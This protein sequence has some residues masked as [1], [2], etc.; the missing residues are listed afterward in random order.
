MTKDE[1][2]T[3]IMNYL[4][5]VPPKPQDALKTYTSMKTCFP[6]AEIPEDLQV[7]MQ[8]S[9]KTELVKLRDQATKQAWQEILR[10][11]DQGK[12]LYRLSDWNPD[13]LVL[14]A[15][16]LSYEGRITNNEGKELVQAILKRSGLS[17]RTRAE[18]WYLQDASNLEMTPTN[19]GFKIVPVTTGATKI[20]IDFKDSTDP[21]VQLFVGMAWRSLS[22]RAEAIKALESAR[23]ATSAYTKHLATFW[24]AFEHWQQGRE[25]ETAGATEAAA[26]EYAAAAQLYEEVS[27]T[28]KGTLYYDQAVADYGSIGQ[29]Y[30]AVKDCALNTQLTSTCSCSTEERGRVLLPSGS[31]VYCCSKKPS[32]KPCECVTD[33]SSAACACKTSRSCEDY[34]IQALCENDPCK[35]SGGQG[36]AS[37]ECAWRGPDCYTKYSGAD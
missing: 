9:T 31:L 15:R 17:P 3:M 5:A 2:F 29:Q 20:V 26:Q 32:D 22:N 16:A 13:D 33:P 35:F 21:D 28:Q 10:I 23:K 36:P 11:Y 25:H 37:W 18:A 4:S 6:D 30:R 19:G 24:L 12:A 1:Y 7:F 14:F 27:N 8:T 34:I